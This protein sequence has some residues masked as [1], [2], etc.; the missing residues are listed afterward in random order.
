MS[1]KIGDEF[2]ET[3]NHAAE[4]EEKRKLQ[5]EILDEFFHEVTNKVDSDMHERFQEITDDAHDDKSLKKA[6]VKAE[7]QGKRP[8]AIGYPQ[9]PNPPFM[10]DSPPDVREILKLE[11]YVALHERC[12]AANVDVMLQMQ[13]SPQGGVMLAVAVIGEAEYGA[14]KK[15][16][17]AAMYPPLPPERDANGEL[18]ADKVVDKDVQI[19]IAEEDPLLDDDDDF[20]DSELFGGR[21]RRGND[22]RGPGGQGF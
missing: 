22:P 14:G 5:M 19:D 4:G 3:F 16:G 1:D 9:P 18:P 8:M 11:G 15:R 10:F 7:M 17:A 6:L 20:D 21:R 13:R 2:R 12:R